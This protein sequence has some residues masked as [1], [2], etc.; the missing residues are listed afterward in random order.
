MSVTSIDTDHEEL[1]LT[2]IA[3]FE[4]APEEVWDLWADPRKL[5]R[6]WGP[7]SHPATVKEHDLSPGG[8]VAYYMTG[9]DDQRF[10]GY[11]EVASVTAGESLE[12]R[13]FFADENW[14]AVDAMPSSVAE[15]RLDASGEGTRMTMRSRY[16]SREDLEKVV[17]MGVIEGLRGAVGQMDDVLVAA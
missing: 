12:F 15:M 1:T 4:A 11:W 3:D 7:P 16:S 2:L 13:D 5:E 17:E 10:Y 14:N 8:R 6:W 9:P